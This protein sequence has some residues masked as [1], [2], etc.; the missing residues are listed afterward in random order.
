MPIELD[1]LKF[2][3]HKLEQAKIPYMLTGSFAANFYA[4]P[5]M[6]RDIDI[7]IEINNPGIDRLFAIFQSD[8]YIDKNSIREAIEQ[9]GMFNIIHNESVFKIDFI[10][11][12][13][14]SYRDAEFRRRKQVQLEKTP[15]W[16]VTPEDL[17]ISKLFWAK[18]SLSEMQL[19]D[20]KNLL[21]SLNNLDEEYMQKWMQKL[22][23]IPIYEKVKTHA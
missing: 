18:D 2:V 23:L 5:R 12:K 3:C 17:I 11:R 14:T 1:I 15:I 16:I 10:I 6:T 4:I 19:K 13:D 21:L 7:V 22:D 8:F 20:V 9:Q